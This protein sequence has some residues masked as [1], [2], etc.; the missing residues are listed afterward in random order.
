MLRNQDEDG[1]ETEFRTILQ[2]TQRDAQKV[3]AMAATEESVP[4]VLRLA[5]SRLADR[6]D[7][8]IDLS[9]PR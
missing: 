1:L 8:L 9:R 5:I 4:E 3:N 7:A 2:E 6:I